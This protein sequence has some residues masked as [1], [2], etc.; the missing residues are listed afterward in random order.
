[1]RKR[2]EGVVWDTIATA[3]W[4][5]AMALCAFPAHA[6]GTL[7]G[8]RIDNTATLTYSLN[9]HA[10][11]PAVAAAPPVVVA[12]VINALVTWQDSAAVPSNSPDT[13]RP[14]SF[15]VT[16]TGNGTETFAL[17][18]NNSVAGVQF[19]PLTPATGSIW[20]ES[21]QQAGFQASGVNGDTLYIAGSNDVTL[22][23]DQSRLVY[24]LSAIPTGQST[25][26]F[27]KVALTATSTTPGASGAVPGTL[28]GTSNGMQVVAGSGR[29]QASAQ[30]SYL[31]S[32]VSIGLT[33]TVSAVRDVN[34]GSR[35]MTGSVL[36]YR[37]VLTV[38]G[39][40]VANGV[41][42]N[43]PL[44]PQVTYVPGSTTVDGAARTDAAD[45][46]EITFAAGAVQASFG[47]IAAPATRVIE[48][49]ATVN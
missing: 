28:L 4:V 45:A 21:G 22:G 37:L 40:G 34:G 42:V 30:G 39:S 23:P 2:G 11:D 12:K 26:A 15:L 8:T 6:T 25:G 43:D 7:A 29:G 24:V 48:F 19:N 36:T 10:A 38:T 41:A 1:M 49:Q 35:V 5:V 16:N 33:K 17:S 3:L 46:D 47:S 27:G 44:P 9:G 18:R 13:N 14:L 31:V 32:G 20:L